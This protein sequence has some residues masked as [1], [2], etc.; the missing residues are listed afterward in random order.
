MWFFNRNKK[1]QPISQD[2]EGR[3][4]DWG[5]QEKAMFGSSKTKNEEF[6]RLGYLVVRN[7][8]DPKDLQEE[9]DYDEGHFLYNNFGKVHKADERQVPGSRARHSYPPYKFY[10]S[11]IRRKMEK[12]IGNE[13]FNTYYYDRVY[14]A[15]QELIKHMDRDVCEISLTYQIGTNCKT[16]WPIWIKTPDTYDDDKNIVKKGKRCLSN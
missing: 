16:P 8:W 12:I 2:A 15:G 10:H 11:Q 6:D 14:Y 1:D 7:I 9:I 4:M 5:P 3:D 13:L